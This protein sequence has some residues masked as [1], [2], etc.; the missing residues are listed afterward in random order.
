MELYFDS[1]VPLD[2]YANRSLNKSLSS[3]FIAFLFFWKWNLWFIDLS[4]WSWARKLLCILSYLSVTAL[5]SS[6]Y[7]EKHV[8]NISKEHGTVRVAIMRYWLKKTSANWFTF[9][10]LCL[11]HSLLPFIMLTGPLFYFLW[12][13]HSPYCLFVQILLSI[14][15]IAASL[16]FIF[17]SYSDWPI[18]FF[19][20]IKT[21][22]HTLMT[23]NWFKF[24]R[25]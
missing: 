17:I 25:Y 8:N 5:L 12:L 6:N 1:Y 7:K 13:V 15:D 16:Y 11:V 2:N 24:W 19:D 3:S 4:R 21:A 18:L 22:F 10:L 20:V 23:A 9:C 14:F